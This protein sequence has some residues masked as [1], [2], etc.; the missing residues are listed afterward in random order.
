M[1]K[2]FL[3]AV[4]LSV[5]TVYGIQYFMGKKGGAE[6]DPGVINLSE[7]QHAP[8]QPIKVPTTQDLY[9]PLNFDVQFLEK[10]V[11]GNEEITEIDT[12]FC[13]LTFSSYGAILQSIDFKEHLGKSNQ[14]LR[15]VYTKSVFDDAQRK[16]GCFLVALDGQ[17]PFFF[18][19]VEKTIGEK[20]SEL[21]Y[22]AETDDWIIIKTFGIFKDSY[23]IDVALDFQ[24]KSDKAKQITPRLFFVAPHI[25]EVPE[26][27]ISI[28]TYN[29]SSDSID[30]RDI[31]KDQ[32]SV[33]YWKE[34]RTI[35]GAEDKYFL[36]TLLSDPAKF[37]KRA[38]FVVHSAQ[39]VQPMLEGFTISAEQKANLSFYMG[40]KVIDHL[41]FVDEKLEEVLSFGWLSW[42]C[43]VLLKLLQWIYDYVHNYG[44]AI[45]LLTILL[46]LP[47]MPFSMYSRK[48]ME[49]YQKYLPTINKI[50]AKYKHDLE[51]QQRE[52]MQFHRDHNISP[53][54]Q[55]IGCLPQLLQIP[56]LFGL[57]R[58][59]MNY[60][61]IYQA[62]FVG[63][64]VDLSAKDPYYIF[65]I[66]MGLS[67]LWQGMMTAVADEKQRV[68]SIF[69]A[70]IMTVVFANFPAGL[71]IYWFMNNILTIGEDYLRRIIYS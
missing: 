34:M 15:T 62:P 66:L 37:V 21:S 26:D 44:I 49:H 56:V 59:L 38:S 33:W 16:L 51:T 18:K 29:E 35:F 48:K 11:P 53:M 24:P 50:R 67:M 10:K 54:T 43:K 28:I 61:D 4:L 31:Q 30:K 9:K 1:D 69:M 47:F 8:G 3:T 27:T 41:S 22:K 12:N 25:A 19:L 36:H 63:W 17:T 70:I 32:S 20:K 5:V 7:Q 40:P 57:Y 46:K 2:K 60:L 52:V 39:S 58:V 64:I 23:Q 71:V 13:K 42:I 68:V 45:I 65:P 14:P 55:M 6:V